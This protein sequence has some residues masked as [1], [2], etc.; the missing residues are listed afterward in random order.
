MSA[1]RRV[2]VIGGGAAGLVTARELLREGI[3]PVIFER[4]EQPGGTWVHDPRA[5]VDPMVADP[6]RAA[7]SLYDS[8]RTNL[9]RDLMAFGDVPFVDQGAGD[10][11]RFPGHAEVRR[12]LEG[13][14]RRFELGPR[15]RTSAAVTRVEPLDGAGGS[16]RVGAPRAPGAWAV[17]WTEAGSVRRERFDAVAVCNGHY[18][19]PRIP[20]LPGLDGFEGVVLHSHAYRRPEPFADQVVA[21][22]GAKASGVDLSRELA[23]VARRVVL[24][25]RE[26]PRADGTGPQGNLD[27]RPGIDRVGPGRLWLSDGTTEAGI[28][29]LVLCTGYHYAFPFL[30]PAAGLLGG[31]PDRVAPLY[32]DLVSVHAETL[33]FVGLPFLVIPFPLFEH[34]ARLWARVLSGRVG[35]P[36]AAERLREVERREARFEASGVPARHRLRYGPLQFPYCEKLAELAGD[37]PPPAWRLPLYAAAS[38]AR[39]VDP[40]GYRDSELPTVDGLG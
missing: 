27:L 38:Q 9:P 39:M 36:S 15:V 2:A 34:Q 25:A 16:W 32:L 3:E 21:L 11:R 14:V 26:G 24:C 31:A 29:A 4:A 12:Y 23:T 40:V 18:Y 5:P 20:A 7:G 35:L 1:V 19:Q 6:R 8:L 13:F 22:L 17:T 30:D 37:A 28:D 33:A 10:A